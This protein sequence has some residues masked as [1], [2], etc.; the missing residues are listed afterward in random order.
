M[1][2]RRPTNDELVDLSW[3]LDSAVV[4]GDRGRAIDTA[5]RL[6]ESLS[7]HEEKLAGAPVDSGATTAALRDACLSLKAS[8]ESLLAGLNR[9]DRFRRVEFRHRVEA[10]AT[11]RVQPA[12]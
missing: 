5:T 11:G 6:L 2:H 8:V 3:L 1:K 4:V 7:R 10:L 9:G 12:A